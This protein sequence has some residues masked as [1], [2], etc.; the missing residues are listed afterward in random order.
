MENLIEY[1]LTNKGA[2]GLIVIVI[3]VISIIGAWIFYKFSLQRYMSNLSNK[4]EKTNHISKVQFETQYTIYQELS[5]VT[6]EM[7]F[8][9]ATAISGAKRYGK[10][11]SKDF[12]RKN[13]KRLL[14]KFLDDAASF[15]RVFF[16]Y[17]PFIDE[18]IYNNLH[19]ILDIV[20]NMTYM[21]VMLKNTKIELD[22]DSEEFNILIDYCGKLI[23]KREEFSKML[24]EHLKSLMFL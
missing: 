2:S 14:D 19:A 9:S 17:S 23:D 16:K 22:I 5:L 4:I 15:K 7:S 6:L 18:N 24:R 13:I 1:I 12:R 11:T 3:L 10:T 20:D 8:S 21:I